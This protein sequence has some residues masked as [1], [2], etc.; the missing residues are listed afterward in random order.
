MSCVK[1]LAIA[2]AVALSGL[3]GKTSDFPVP[4]ISNYSITNEVN[5]LGKSNPMQRIVVTNT[6]PGTNY[7]LL[8]RDF[9]DNSAN[10]GHYWTTN[11][12]KPATTN[13]VTFETTYNP[14]KNYQFFKVQGNFNTN[15]TP[16]LQ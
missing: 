3:E 7:C 8:T 4:F 15:T 5:G 13:F 6:V 11:Q 14:N 9:L 16:L 1:P 10:Q 2:G 12:T